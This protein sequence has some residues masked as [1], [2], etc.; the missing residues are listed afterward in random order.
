LVGCARPVRPWGA[1]RAFG[2]LV[3]SRVRRPN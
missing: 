2:D 1:V 3:L